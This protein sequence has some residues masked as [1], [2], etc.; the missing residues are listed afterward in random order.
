MADQGVD[1]SEGKLEGLSLGILEGL[2]EGIS[3]GLSER[4]SVGTFNSW[5]E[6][7]KKILVGLFVLCLDFFVGRLLVGRRLVGLFVL[8]AVV[9]LAVPFN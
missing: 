3:E 1:F 2:A 6:I 8:G 9:G 5:K 4:R 7:R